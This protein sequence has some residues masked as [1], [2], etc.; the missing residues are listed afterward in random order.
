MPKLPDVEC[1]IKE[2][3]RRGFWVGYRTTARRAIPNSPHACVDSSAQSGE[4][5][6][7][8]DIDWCDGWLLVDFG[9]GA[10]IVNQPLRR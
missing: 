9:R 6:I 4:L 10:I 3:R 1:R 7:I 8:E 5:G 2:I